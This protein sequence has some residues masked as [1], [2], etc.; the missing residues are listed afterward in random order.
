M[1]G[2]LWFPSG[3][4][5]TWVQAKLPASATHTDGTPGRDAPTYHLPSLGY[6][7]PYLLL[8]LD[9]PTP[10]RPTLICPQ[11]RLAQP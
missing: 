11:P 4:P 6:P 1:L 5:E 10:V 3:L 7:C 8:P 9:F 2:N